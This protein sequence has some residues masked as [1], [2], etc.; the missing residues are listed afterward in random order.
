MIQANIKY[1]LQGL[2]NEDLLLFVIC[3]LVAFEDRCPKRDKHVRNLENSSFTANNSSE[4]SFF[5]A[6]DFKHSSGEGMKTPTRIFAMRDRRTSRQ[7]FSHVGTRPCV[8]LTVT[9]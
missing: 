9:K 6:S 2:L 3:L 1:T 5:Y 8:C 7:I 4:L